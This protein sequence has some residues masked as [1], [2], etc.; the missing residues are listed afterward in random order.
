MGFSNFEDDSFIS[1]HSDFLNFIFIGV[2]WEG[3][4]T[5]KSQL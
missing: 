4:L 2:K 5:A 3:P 1:F